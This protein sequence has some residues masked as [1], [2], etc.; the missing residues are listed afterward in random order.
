MLTTTPP[1]LTSLNA[2]LLMHKVVQKRSPASLRWQCSKAVILSTCNRTEVTP[3]P[4]LYQGF[5]DIRHFLAP[6]LVLTSKR[7]TLTYMNRRQPHV[8]F[9][10]A[11]GR[12]S[13]GAW[14]RRST[15]SSQ[16][17]LEI[18][19]ARGQHSTL[20]LLFRHCLET[21]KRARARLILRENCLV[22]TW[23]WQ[24]TTWVLLTMQH[25]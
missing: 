9:S 6:P 7:L 8:L 21:G 25:R 23:K 20:N 1:L 11:A 12:N 14:R 19:Q 3:W 2:S 16:R 5:D 10:V 4:A 17:C 22:I 15:R 13:A 18:A 24:L